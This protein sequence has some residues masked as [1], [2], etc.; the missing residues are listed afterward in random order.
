MILALFLC[1]NSLSSFGQRE[2]ITL[3]PLGSSATVDEDTQVSLIR[4]EYDSQQQTMEFELDVDTTYLDDNIQ[5]GV[6][7]L[8]GSETQITLKAAYYCDT[9]L[10]FQAKDVPQSAY[11]Q[12]YCV[13]SV[14]GSDGT[15]SQYQLSF[16][17]AEDSVIQQTDSLNLDKTEKEYLL[18]S[19]EANYNLLG[20]QLEQLI[21]QED[22]LT[23]QIASAQAQ[24]T[25]LQNALDSMTSAER[26]QANAR[27]TSLQTQRSQDETTL[28]TVQ[29][30]I[31]DTEQEM[32]A[33]QEKARVL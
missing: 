18:A 28:K 8:A 4:W 15:T 19:Y 11:Y 22:Y 30:N 20:E 16:W 5:F 7:L 26:S 2:V 14:T 31:S 25:T 32:A 12:I 3:T 9:F 21:Q 23:A 29:Q 17:G 24:I 1:S 6:N 33:L 27:I 13:V 10:V